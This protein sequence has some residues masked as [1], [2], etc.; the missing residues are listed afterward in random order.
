MAFFT[1]NFGDRV[2]RVTRVILVAA[3]VIVAALLIT[4]PGRPAS[5]NPFVV[6]RANA[7]AVSA[8][9]GYI[10]LTTRATENDRF[11]IIDTNKQVICVYNIQSGQLRLV[12]ARKFDFDSKIWD[13]SV[14]LTQL[15][16]NPNL[17]SFENGDGIFRDPPPP[18][19]DQ[20]ANC[21]KNYSEAWQKQWE[22]N[23]KKK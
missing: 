16:G 23:V 3:I 2:A 18:P 19:G 10:A 15:S 14:D 8:A 21:A 9:P 20:N 12:A 6:G 17:K 22:L 11:Y 7:D 13:A 1:D 5:L 4:S